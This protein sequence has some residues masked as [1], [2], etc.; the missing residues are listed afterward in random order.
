MNV[1]HES[2]EDD[3][4]SID[5]GRLF[6]ALAARRRWILGPSL[7][8]L[9]LSLAYVEI[10]SPRYTGVTKVLIEN[11][12]GYLTRADKAGTDATPA[13]DAEA[14]ASAVETLTTMDVA[15]KIA[16]RLALTGNPEFNPALSGGSMLARIFGAGDSAK[17]DAAMLDA[18]LAR[19]TVFAQTKSRVMQVE[20]VSKDP[21]LA[22]K[23][24]NAAAQVFLENQQKA[25]QD[26]ARSA[27]DW[28]A[29]KIEDLRKKVAETG[30]KVEAFRSQSGL[31][32]GGAEST[33][34]GQQLTD[35]NTQLATLRASQAEANAKART[36]RALIKDGRIG[37][38]PEAAKDDSL[39]RFIEQRTTLRAQIASESKTLLPQHPRMLSLQAELSALD[40]EIQNAAARAVR[41]FENVA[42]QSAAQVEDLTA[43]LNAQS[44]TVSSGNADD[45]Q[46]KSLELDAKSAS[47]QLASYVDK[48][49]EASAREADNSA[50]PDAR[51]IA[52]AVPPRLPTFPQKLP[53]VALSTLAALLLSC[54]AASTQALL[55][56]PGDIKRPL[57]TRGEFRETPVAGTA[58]PAPPFHPADDGDLAE[59]LLA[60]AG[61]GEPLVVAVGGADSPRAL[62]AALGLA[63]R[64]GEARRTVLV[65]CGEAQDWLFD[66]LA[67]HEGEGVGH[68]GLAE[69]SR[70]QAGFAAALNADLA[71][72]TDIIAR[73]AG[74]ID[75]QAL[76][77][78]FDA[79]AGT[80]DCVLIACS[81]WRSAEFKAALGR[82]AVAV[83]VGPAA[84]AE[85]AAGLLRRATEADGVSVV[86][87]AAPEEAAP[88]A[89]AA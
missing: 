22:A 67:P 70:G 64:L 19:L 42:R 28:L 38:V 3:G 49:R 11:Q 33:V 52:S 81:D 79:L 9:A 61:Q 74:M 66:V 27:S 55:G 88:V 60:A 10:A 63:R 36:L 65:D 34:S 76:P 80:Y 7:A 68:A 18:V 17:S 5:L 15:R 83:L 30:A 48:Y 85:A 51:V 39:R 59:R 6:R 56:D 89:A 46:L 72:E 40:G 44:K 2:S 45:V 23:G 47:D 73:G 13:L 24:A 77:E 26:A 82:A 62:A 57:R 29:K 21:E 12:E 20:F 69:L 43:A 86:T 1:S 53:I 31:L 41:G 58:R 8:A 50:P 78:L 16:D 4:Q 87:S 54:G 35:L 75:A 84:A 25:K 71:G 37:E 32:K 14:I